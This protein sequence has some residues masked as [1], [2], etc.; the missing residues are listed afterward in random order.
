VSDLPKATLGRTGLEVTRLGYGAMELRGG[1]RR[2]STPEA[3]G[4]LLNAVLDAGISW[5]DTSP[6]YGGSEEA[7]GEH[8]S[9]R[10]D[11]FFLASK[12]GC[13]IDVPAPAPGQ[14][15]P[16]VFTRENIRA[17]VER[18]LRRM[19]TDHLDLVQ[20]HISPSRAV[21]EQNESVAEL[22][23]L[24]SEGKLRFIGMSGTLPH[25]ADHIEMGCFDA[26]QIPYSALEREHEELI[27]R[28][29]AA[30]AGIVVRGGVARGVAVA[31]DETLARLPDVFRE[32]IEGRR[33]LWEKAGLADLCGELSEMEL[34]LRFTLS[35][36][37][38]STTIV[39]TA[40]LEHLADNVAAA[41]KGPLPDALYAQI[42]QRLT[43]AAAAR[44]AH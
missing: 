33:E 10:R 30:G 4:R 8:I 42:K 2:V 14:R 31:T 39:G 19:R 36:P 27:S 15:P 7:I 11:A 40:N 25:L 32:R 17:G 13:P 9:H 1:R 18:S 3:V 6:D 22:E 5:I 41:R 16:H 20:F 37:A 21:L 34:M 38:M 29:A 35:H 24:R 28:A 26:F 43:E 23:S 44:G 12:C